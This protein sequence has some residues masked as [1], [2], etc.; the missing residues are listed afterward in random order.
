MSE[1]N[2][3]PLLDIQLVTWNGQKYLPACLTSL[4]DQSFTSWQLLALDNGSSDNSLQQLANF[5]SQHPGQVS[6]NGFNQGFATAHNE[7]FDHG[8]APYVLV[9]NQDIILAKNYLAELI[10]YLQRNSLAGS[11]SG[12][13]LKLSESE[14]GFAK[15]TVIDS[16]G[17]KIFPSYRVVE[18]RR[19]DIWTFKRGGVIETFGVPA[20]AAIY[21]RTALE[22]IKLPT[23]AGP[24]FAGFFGSYKEDVD[25]AY[26][27]QLRGWG[28]V[29]LVEALGYH[30]RSLSGGG[31]SALT[32]GSWSTVR[33]QYKR[34]FAQA[35]NSYRNHLYFLASV[36]RL[37]WWRATLAT[38]VYE[39]LK[40]IWIFITRPALL[41]AW[42]D[43]RA[44]SKLLQKKKKLISD[45]PCE[46]DRIKYWMTQ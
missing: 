28:S 30:V 20:T 16:L 2:S 12:L 15:T 7:L 24:Y 41:A 19:G 39:V 45:S 5:V 14:S 29:C 22:S 21:R 38:T 36:P 42:Q 4:A 35:K 46:L 9:L 27:L 31:D 6:Q 1:I 17:L 32:L 26:R 40:L 34:N 44:E 3:K 11:A 33:R 18:Q 25:L 37:T 8:Q 23:E 13:L 43:V 10:D